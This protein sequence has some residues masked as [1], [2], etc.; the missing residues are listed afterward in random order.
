MLAAISRALEERDQTQ[1]H[2]ARVA[3][4]AESVAQELGWEPERI[5]TL[6]FGAHLHDIG[7]LAVR[8]SV[9][10]KPGPLTPAEESEMRVHPRAG[11]SLVLPLREG[12]LALPCVLFHHE[13]WD[14]LG[15]PSGLHGR[16]IPLEARLIAV[17]DAFDAMTSLRPYSA[18]L[19]IDHALAEIGRCAGTQFDPAVAE[20]FL[21]VWSDR[22]ADWQERVA[23]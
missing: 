23:S 21:D 8:R 14:G 12:R 18:A 11:A 20:L 9:L 3:A 10:R 17:A 7:K 4:F 13:R 6:R 19:S 22:T 16:S 5:A 15:Y 1:G 2:G